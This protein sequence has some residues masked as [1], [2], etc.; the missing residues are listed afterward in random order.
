MIENSFGKQNRQIYIHQVKERDF[1]LL[2]IYMS[3]IMLV[4]LMM[5]HT[6]WN[7]LT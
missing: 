6:I 3:D 1:L 5:I 2:Q 7:Y 4:P